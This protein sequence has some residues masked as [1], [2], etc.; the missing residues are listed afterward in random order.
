MNNIE[1][2]EQIEKNMNELNNKDYTFKFK[3]ENVERFN[4]VEIAEIITRLF[5]IRFNDYNS[6]SV[7]FRPIE[8]NIN[9]DYSTE[10][11]TNVKKIRIYTF[12]R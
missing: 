11:E 9:I 3:L 5:K 1:L 12:D 7:C 2:L 10:T 6:Y 8:R 4:T